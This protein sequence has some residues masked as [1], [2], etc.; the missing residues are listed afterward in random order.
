VPY[1]TRARS[2]A[3]AEALPAGLEEFASWAEAEIAD[4]EFCRNGA[5]AEAD[6][7]PEIMVTVRR[8][9]AAIL[10]TAMQRTTCSLHRKSLTCVPGRAL[11]AR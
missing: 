2:K 1:G 7:W 3:D 8:E 11:S 9:A 5:Q 4:L 10:K 6:E